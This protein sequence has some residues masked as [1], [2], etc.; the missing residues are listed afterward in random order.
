M[1]KNDMVQA[2]ELLLL[3]QVLE[4]S[5]KAFGNFHT[6]Y[7]RLVISCVR[8]VF[9]KH[10]VDVSQE[11]LEDTVGQ[12]FL[13]MVKDDYRKLRLYDSDKGYKFS[14]WI[15]LIATNTAYDHLRKRTPKTT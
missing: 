8:R 12:A 13:N 7:R 6:R 11:D 15:G 4:G 10:T 14:S 5:T 1:A 9:L 3:S 2:E